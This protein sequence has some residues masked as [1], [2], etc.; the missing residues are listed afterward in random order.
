LRTWLAVI[1]GLLFV[2]FMFQNSQQETIDVFF[3]DVSAP[4]IFSLLVSAVVGVV[5][6]YV[7]ARQR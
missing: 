5:I 2:V 3:W 7:M 1:A 4:L 6:G